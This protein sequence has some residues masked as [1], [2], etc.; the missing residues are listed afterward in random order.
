MFGLGFG[1]VVFL[2]IVVLV[3][4]ANTAKVLNEYERCVIFRLGKTTRALVNIGG[5]GNGPGLVILVP[6]IDKL[7]RVNLQTITMDVPVQEVITKD[8]VPCKVNAV[9]YFKVIDPQRAV[10]EVQN[11][12]MASGACSGRSTS[13]K[14]SPTGRKSIPNCSKSSTSKPTPGASKCR[15]WK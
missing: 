13:M 2:L 14:S 5:N 11:Y 10:I 3:F 1:T 4:I 6:F 15:S 9:C 12:I 7:I 8:N